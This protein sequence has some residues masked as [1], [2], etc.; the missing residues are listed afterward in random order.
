MDIF[1]RQA[2]SSSTIEGELQKEEMRYFILECELKTAGYVFIKFNSSPENIS[3]ITPSL[4]IKRFYLRKE[5]YGSGGSQFMMQKIF[6][7]AEENGMKSCWLT[8]W[9]LNPRAVRFYEKCGFKIAG[10]ML[11]K[12]GNRID[13]DWVMVRN[14]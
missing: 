1:V 2:F 4:E 3:V 7:L 14:L 12:M 5:F 13:E 8:V 10:T 6:S 9:D 11:F